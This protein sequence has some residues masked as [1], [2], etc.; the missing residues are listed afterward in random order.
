MAR[1]FITGS[2]D[3]LGHLAAKVLADQGHQVVLHARNA[4]RAREA[5][6]R[7]PA[8]ENVLIGDLSD[9]EETKKL[10]HRS[11]CNGQ[12]RCRDT[13]CRYLQSAVKNDVCGQHT[14]T[15]RSG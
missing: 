3:G 12:L 2:A 15:R 5:L 1:I 13:Q 11:E 6:R 7:V 10:G 14:R 4:E 9:I 8:A